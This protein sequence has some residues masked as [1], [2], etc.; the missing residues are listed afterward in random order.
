M[1]GL[2]RR[3]GEGCT[4]LSSDVAVIEIQ[5]WEAVMKSARY[6]SCFAARCWLRPNLIPEI[7]MAP[8]IMSQRLQ[9]DE[10]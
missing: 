5:A 10:E 6:D 3:P 8:V 2:L 4:I 1:C 9:E 7:G